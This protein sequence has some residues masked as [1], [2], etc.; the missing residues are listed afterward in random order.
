[1]KINLGAIWSLAKPVVK[2]AAVAIV[3]REVAK[4]AAKTGV[5][6]VLIGAAVEQLQKRAGV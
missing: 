3:T 6:G 2:A 4:K 1:M 5:G